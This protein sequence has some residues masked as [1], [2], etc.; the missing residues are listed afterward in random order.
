MD[1]CQIVLP[2][3]DFVEHHKDWRCLPPSEDNILTESACFV[4]LPVIHYTSSVLLHLQCFITHQ[5]VSILFGLHYLGAQFHR[6]NFLRH[7]RSQVLSCVAKQLC[8]P[9]MRKG[10]IE[11]LWLGCILTFHGRW[12]TCMLQ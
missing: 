8:K 12:A 4:T 11:T 10:Y 3:V 7:W 2:G 1:S 5:G 6:D 9:D